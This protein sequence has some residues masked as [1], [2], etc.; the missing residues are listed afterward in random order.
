MLAPFPGD[1]PPTLG[2]AVHKFTLQLVNQW[3]DSTQSHVSG[4][5]PWRCA[6]DVLPENGGCRRVQEQDGGVGHDSA[7]AVNNTVRA[8]RAFERFNAS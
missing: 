4:T 7:E 3:C 8:W 1:H 6:G 2:Q 5:S